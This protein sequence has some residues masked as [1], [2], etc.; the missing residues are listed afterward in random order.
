MMPARLFFGL[1]AAALF[2]LI[3][4][5][6]RRIVQL[7]GW[8]GLQRTPVAFHRL[9]CL[10]LRVRLRRFGMPTR[11]RKRLIAANHVSWLDI[12]VLGALEPMTF[13]AKKEVG[14]P[15]LGRQVALL[16]GVVFVDRRRKRAIPDVNKAMALTMRAG[17]PVVLFAEATTGDG[18]RLRRFRSSHFEAVRQACDDN[19]DDAV[20]QPIFLHYSRIAG[21]PV[22]R[23]DRP[24]VAWYGDM[25]F[26]PHLWRVIFSGGVACDVYY[27]DP[28]QV[29][30][31]SSRKSLAL[32]SER[33]I[34]R[35]A[36]RA[37]ETAGFR[38]GPAIPPA[39]ETR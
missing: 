29:R 8:P 18:N 12:L 38:A 16:Q 1:L 15:F 24:T 32:A 10:T 36:T 34:K 35:L 21:L 2:L 25:T 9:L 4:G 6:A 23:L 27:G 28:L 31:D 7:M 30:P 5:P 14:G 26:F 33:A 13:L 17:V 20:V 3:F 19:S 39:L 37:R 22:A 11:A